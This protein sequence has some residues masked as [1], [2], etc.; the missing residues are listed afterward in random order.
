[1]VTAM[2]KRTVPVSGHER[3][4]HTVRPHVRVVDAPAAA[5]PGVDLAAVKDQAA[6]DPFA[7]PAGDDQPALT[8]RP[9]EHGWVA[10]DG[11]AS[12]GVRPDGQLDPGRWV[13]PDPTPDHPERTVIVQ[14]GNKG[15]VNVTYNGLSTLDRFATVPPGDARDGWVDQGRQAVDAL[16][17][18]VLSE[19]PAEDLAPCPHDFDKTDPVYEYQSRLGHHI[20]RVAKTCRRCGYSSTY[21]THGPAPAGT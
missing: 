7:V 11:A 14:F 20:Y 18:R 10:T 8:L 6:A 1:M 19:V 21:T 17:D 4:G 5:P 9:L 15:K 12:I 13:H 2:A 16:R 3:G